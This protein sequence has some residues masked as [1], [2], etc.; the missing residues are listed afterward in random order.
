MERG[1]DS[2]CFFNLRARTTYYLAYNCWGSISNEDKDELEINQSAKSQGALLQGTNV[3]AYDSSDLD[4]ATNNFSLANKIGHGGFGNVYKG[5]LEN[6]VEIAVKKQDVTS[7]QG[8]TE[9]ENEFKLIAKLQHRNL[10]K[11]LGY[12]INGAEKFLVYEFMANN[13][14]DKVIFGMTS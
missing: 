5:V 7:R 6:G 8:F 11:L 9:F 3:I 10:T 12:C 14:L 13:S 1:M 2:F 4:A